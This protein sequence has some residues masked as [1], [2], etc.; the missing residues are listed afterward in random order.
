[1]STELLKNLESHCPL[2]EKLVWFRLDD[3]DSVDINAPMLKSFDFTGII[4]SICLKNV[5]RLLKVSL[6]G[7]D[8]SAQHLDFAKVFKSCPALEHL[9]I[10]FNFAVYSAKDDNRILESLELEHFSDMTLNYLREVELKCYAGTPRE[11]QLIKLLL[12]KSPVLVKMLIDRRS[13]LLETR[14]NLFD[15]VSSFILASP[16]A[17][18]VYI[19]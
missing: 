13:G 11:M 2:L 10:N 8:M 6:T 4:S 7:F 18:V 16:K 1:M 12:A 17:E 19:D 3:G 5:P 15:E 14:V 9:L